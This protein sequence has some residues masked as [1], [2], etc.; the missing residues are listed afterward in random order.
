[1]PSFFGGIFK[2]K[3]THFC[4]SCQQMIAEV[5]LMFLRQGCTEAKNRKQGLTG[6]EVAKKIAKKTDRASAGEGG[7]TVLNNAV[8]YSSSRARERR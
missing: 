4:L 7:E 5:D 8:N 1:M 6:K 3:K 2:E